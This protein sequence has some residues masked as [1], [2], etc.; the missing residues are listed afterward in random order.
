MKV[1]YTGFLTKYC[2]L[3]TDGKQHKNLT[4]HCLGFLQSEQSILAVSLWNGHG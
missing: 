1:Y 2:G 4:H 3:P